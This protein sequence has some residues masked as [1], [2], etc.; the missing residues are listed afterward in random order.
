MT[1][2]GIYIILEYEKNKNPWYLVNEE[3]EFQRP[4]YK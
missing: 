3:F 4:S 1:R 2:K